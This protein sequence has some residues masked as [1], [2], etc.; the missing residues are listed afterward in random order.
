MEDGPTPGQDGHFAA[1][2]RVS[3][4]EDVQRFKTRVD[5]AIQQIH[6]CQLAPGFDRI[7]AP[8][9]KEWLN[10]EIYRKDGIPLNAVTLAELRQ[11][12]TNFSVDMTPYPSI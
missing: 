12:A 4:F 11:A 8:G 10:W 3:A 9:E 2:I 7:Y 1:V 6:E 5:R